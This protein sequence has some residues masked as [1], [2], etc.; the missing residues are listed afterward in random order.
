MAR[1]CRVG[2][3][4]QQESGAVQAI[5]TSG[6]LRLGGQAANFPA[7]AVNLSTQ[8]D[9]L[10][11][12]TAIPDIVL[13]S[14]ATFDVVAGDPSV[15]LSIDPAGL[16]PPG[17]TLTQIN[18]QTVRYT[19]PSGTLIGDLPDDDIELSTSPASV[20]ASVAAG[21][22]ATPTELTI[23]GNGVDQGQTLHVNAL[24]GG[25][26]QLPQISSSWVD[27]TPTPGPYN[28]GDTMT[29]DLS[30]ANSGTEALILNGS[31]ASG[32]SAVADSSTFMREQIAAGATLT[33]PVTYTVDSF[34]P[35]AFVPTQALDAD[36]TSIA[37]I[38]IPI[39]LAGGGGGPI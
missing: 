1:A 36:G 38:A 32:M 29:F 14:A 21:Q 34:A 12:R 23:I 13:T 31:L 16:L 37:S 19:I 24:A 6:E 2:T 35:T 30:W 25:D 20:I 3:I 5:A 18:P 39:P 17:V 27:T 4:E 11:Q 28:S 9:L 7:A 15:E 22:E 33:V 10:F 8:L 26:G